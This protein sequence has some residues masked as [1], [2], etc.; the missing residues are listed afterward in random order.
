[1]KKAIPVSQINAHV[2]IPNLF[3]DDNMCVEILKPRQTN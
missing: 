1:M 2:V 3:W